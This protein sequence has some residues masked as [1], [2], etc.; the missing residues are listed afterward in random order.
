MFS[1]RWTNQRGD[2]ATWMQAFLGELDRQRLPPPDDRRKVT[3]YW[4]QAIEPKLAVIFYMRKAM[5][6]YSLQELRDR[7]RLMDRRAELCVKSH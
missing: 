2:Y 3:F 4:R 5:A 6:N 7:Q 1:Y